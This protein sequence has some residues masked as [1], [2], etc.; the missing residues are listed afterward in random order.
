MMAVTNIGRADDYTGELR[1]AD[2][3]TKPSCRR[4]LQSRHSAVSRPC[5]DDGV[6]ALGELPRVVNRGRLHRRRLNRI[7]DDQSDVRRLGPQPSFRHH[8]AGADD[9]DRDDRQ[10]RFDREQEAARLEFRD[11]TVAAAGAFRIDDQRRLRDQR[12]PPLENAGAIGILAVDEEMLAAFQMPA[13]HRKFRQRLLRD[14]PQLVRQR[15]EDDRRV[16]V[17]LMV[18]DED[19]V[20]AGL[21]TLETFDGD[22][23]AGRLQ[24]QPR[25]RART[26]V[27][28]V[29]A[30]VEQARDDRRRAEDDGV[31]A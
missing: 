24:N 25:P 30:R 3:D 22:A 11:M 4:I 14:D 17:A 26:A 20:R 7:V 9:R 29:A 27:S 6:H 16:V 5:R 28:E 13:E 31:D 15:R 19:V 18:R 12:P 10:L 21:Q 1:N 23:N 8:R 2:A